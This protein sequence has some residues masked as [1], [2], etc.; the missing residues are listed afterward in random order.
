MSENVA[1]GNGGVDGEIRSAVAARGELGAAYDDVVAEGLVE[2]IGEEIDRRIDARLGVSSASRGPYTAPAPRTGGAGAPS[3]WCGPG[4][5]WPWR[6][7]PPVP[8]SS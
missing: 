6:C 1:H 5:H 8:G 4:A 3:G 7:S 2:R